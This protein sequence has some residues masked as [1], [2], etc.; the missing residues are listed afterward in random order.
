MPRGFIN[1]ENNQV[2]TNDYKYYNCSKY[3]NDGLTKFV[4]CEPTTMKQS[5][6][7]C[8]RNNDDYTIVKSISNDWKLS[9]VNELLVI[10]TNDIYTYLKRVRTGF[11]RLETQIKV[12]NLKE[13]MELKNNIKLING[14]YNKIIHGKN[15]SL[16]T[17]KWDLLYINMGSQ[18]YSVFAHGKYI[19]KIINCAKPFRCIKDVIMQAYVSER[20][21]RVPIIYDSFMFEYNENTYNMIISENIGNQTLYSLI[22]SN[23]ITENIFY[24][25][26]IAIIEIINVGVKIDQDRNLHNAIWDGQKVIII[27]IGSSNLKLFDINDI[28][29]KKVYTES[30]IISMLAYILNMVRNNDTIMKYLTN[31]L[32]KCITAELFN[33]DEDT[34]SKEGQMLSADNITSIKQMLKTKE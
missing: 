11:L 32:H 29:N 30:L 26:F 5:S 31:A 13:I 7:V 34:L 19:I 15:H 23:N 16:S 9:I 17:L 2:S 6:Y 14:I 20:T 12:E 21:Y 25:Y 27:D 33:I 8:A 10:D 1:C 4:N 22:K 28:D 3:T 24:D 18:T